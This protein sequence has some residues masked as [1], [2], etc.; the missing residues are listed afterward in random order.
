[1]MNIF[2]KIVNGYK[3]LTIFERVSDVWHDLEYTSDKRFSY[4]LRRLCFLKN[5]QEVIS[6]TSICLPVPVKEEARFELLL[7][8]S[9][10]EKLI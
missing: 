9:Y 5:K 1:M 3:P 10:I 7:H 8:T 6:T 2:P 4:V